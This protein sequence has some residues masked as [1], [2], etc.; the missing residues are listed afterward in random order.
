MK[1]KATE[2]EDNILPFVKPDGNKPKEDNWLKELP[3]GSIFLA[4]P[5]ASAGF[6][7]NEFLRGSDL[8]EEVLLLV[9]YYATGQPVQYFVD[10]AVYS[11]SMKLVKVREV[12]QEE[13]K[14]E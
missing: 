4:K 2:I 11:K 3:V 6:I 13:Q 1:A 7:V 8:T 14:E 5:K 10:S 9:E 12:P